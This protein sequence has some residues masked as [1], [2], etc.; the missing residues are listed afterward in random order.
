MLSKKQGLV[1]TVWKQVLLKT[2]RRNIN[3]PFCPAGVQSQWSVDPLK[4]NNYPVNSEFLIVNASHPLANRGA[5]AAGISRPSFE[6]S[7]LVRR[8]PPLAFSLLEHECVHMWI[9]F[10]NFCLLYVLTEG[11]GRG[12]SSIWRR[13]RRAR[14]PTTG[15][16]LWKAT[17]SPRVE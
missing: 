11:W 16:L 10:L 15:E 13:R 6:I 4:L 3:R 5:Q 17:H 14:R 1:L 7:H 2:K 9:N 12:C 8:P